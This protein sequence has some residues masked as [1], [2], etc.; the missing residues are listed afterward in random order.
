MVIGGGDTSRRRG[1]AA[2]DGARDGRTPWTVLQLVDGG[3][4][5]SLCPSP[6]QQPRRR[7]AVGVDEMVH[8]RLG[9][10]TDRLVRGAQ[11]VDQLDLLPRPQAWADSPELRREPAGDRYGRTTNREVGADETLIAGE[12]AGRWAMVDRA[13]PRV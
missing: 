8:S 6:A 4:G 1:P 12:E 13:V 2:Q 5:T 10:P 7:H 11:P 3:V 9:I